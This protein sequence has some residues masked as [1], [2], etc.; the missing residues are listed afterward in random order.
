MNPVEESAHFRPLEELLTELS[1]RD[2]IL[3]AVNDK[4]RIDAPKGVLTFELR[5]ALTEHKTAL[6]EL[7]RGVSKNETPDQ[8]PQVIEQTI[9]AVPTVQETS[10]LEQELDELLAQ[11]RPLNRH[12]KIQWARGKK[13]PLKALLHASHLWLS[14]DL[15]DWTAANDTIFQFI[16]P[17]GNQQLCYRRYR[18]V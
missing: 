16:S 15:A 12:W 13:V 3:S 5:Q 9:I 1:Q 18:R 4:L 10:P 14:D 7:L 17:F 11:L 8:R 6:M 2:V